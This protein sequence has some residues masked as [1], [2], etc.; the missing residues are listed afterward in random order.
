MEWWP[1][2][3]RKMWNVGAIFVELV[4]ILHHDSSVYLWCLQTLSSTSPDLQSRKQNLK[5]AWS[6]IF[7]PILLPCI[8]LVNNCKCFIF[9]LLFLQKITTLS[10]I[11]YFTP[12]ICQKLVQQ[13]ERAAWRKVCSFSL[14]LWLLSDWLNLK[15]VSSPDV[16][17]ANL[18]SSI[19]VS[20]LVA[21]FSPERKFQLGSFI[22][23][24]KANL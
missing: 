5:I 13:I 22:Y 10:K 20:I 24:A 1:W 6:A 12:E 15:S 16:C 23:F 18:C 8:S 11:S 2:L 17:Y 7:F 3:W 14:I 21:N 9:S 4:G 19:R